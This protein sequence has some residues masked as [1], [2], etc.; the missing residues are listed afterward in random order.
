MRTAKEFSDGFNDEESA[1]SEQYLTFLLNEQAYA[2]DILN[3]Q[4]IQGWVSCTPLPNTPDHILG[5]INLRGAIVPIID[6]RIR[7]NTPSVEYNDLT[8]VVVVKVRHGD[9]EK[10]VGLVVDAVSEVYN[11]YQKQLNA[12]PEFGAG[13]DIAYVQELAM[14][15]DSLVIILNVDKL[16]EES[17]LANLDIPN[18]A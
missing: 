9:S 3:I 10:V 1:D 5:V 16:I 6:L 8:V 7:F 13:V 11:I 14:V 4:G 18:V 12:P 17:V 2:V 15:N